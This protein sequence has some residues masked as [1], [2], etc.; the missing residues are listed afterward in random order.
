MREITIAEVTTRLKRVRDSLQYEAKRADEESDVKGTS[1]KI[2]Y[3][4]GGKATAYR[5]AARCIHNALA[6]MGLV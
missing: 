6:D 1:E 4:L 5:D 2:Q 3:M